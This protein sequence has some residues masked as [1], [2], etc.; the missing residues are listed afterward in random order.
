MSLQTGGGV[1]G[2]GGELGDLVLPGGDPERAPPFGCS[3]DGRS[4][5]CRP[6]ARLGLRG[7]THDV[8]EYVDARSR[9]E[10]SKRVQ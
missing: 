2:I 3:E 4:R 6:C 1:P 9:G 10:Q 7:N 5:V 8:I